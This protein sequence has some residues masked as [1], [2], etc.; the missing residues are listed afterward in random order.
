MNL[1]QNKFFVGLGAVLAIGCLGL[2][3]MLYQSYSSYDAANTVYQD[4]VAKLQQLQSLPLYPEPANLKVL[5]EQKKVAAESAVTLHQQLV[6]MSFPLEPL[7]PEQFQDQ[8]N[9]TVKALVE[10]AAKAGVALSD[11][12]YLGFSEYR[13]AT[14]KPEAAAVLGRQLKCVE[15]AVSTLIDRKVAS[16]DKITRTPLPEEQDPAKLQTTEVKPKQTGPSKPALLSKFPF[17]IQFIGEQKAFQGAMNDLSKNDKQFF[18]IRPLLIKNQQEKTPKKID[19]A[20]EKAAAAAA[21]VAAVNA[22]AVTSGTSAPQPT[23]PPEK[24]KYVLGAEKLNVILRFDSVVFAS[25]LPK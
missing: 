23:P 20:A 8:L 9:A 14:P 17:E 5:E 13:T 24:M 7:T 4:Q 25:T 16:I 15:L 10:R 12:Q 2:G 19:P 22:A 3:W 21:S 18:I 1:G 11:K 6:P